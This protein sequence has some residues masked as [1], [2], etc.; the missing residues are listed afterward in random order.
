MNRIK[1]KQEKFWELDFGKN[2]SIR[3]TVSKE[4]FQNSSFQYI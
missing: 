3:N 2:Y 1:T 4:S